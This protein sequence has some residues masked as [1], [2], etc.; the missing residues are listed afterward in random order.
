MSKR[1]SLRC[2]KCNSKSIGTTCRVMTP[3]YMEI[4]YTC[5][6]TY[7]GHVFVASLE[8]IRTLSPGAFPNPPGI[9]VPLS[10]HIKRRKLIEE[11][12]RCLEAPD[13]FVDETKI[14]EHV[15][16]LDIFQQ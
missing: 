8:A 13:S 3:I 4:T 5:Q 7:C 10:K 1:V 9:N 14:P 12:E 6:N 16:Q 2:W 11:L 15:K